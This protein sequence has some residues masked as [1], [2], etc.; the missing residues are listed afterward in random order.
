MS[1]VILT[2]AFF[3][4]IYMIV[5]TVVNSPSE[6]NKEVVETLLKVKNFV[7]YCETH[8]D[9]LPENIRERFDEMEA[10]LLDGGIK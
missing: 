4:T 10:A 7:D 1:D 9:E 2:L 8:K 3:F 6:P 5:S